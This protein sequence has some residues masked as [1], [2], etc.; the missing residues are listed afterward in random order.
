MNSRQAGFATRQ[1]IIRGVL[2]ALIAWTGTAVH[3]GGF[4]RAI[5]AT[6]PRVVKLYGLSAG[7]EKGYGSGVLVS[8]GGRVLTVFSLLIDSRDIRAVAFDGTTYGA[9]VVARDRDL[10]L[11]LLQLKPV[12]SSEGS[13]AAEF[14]ESFPFFE[15]SHETVL[16]P[17]D[18]VLS[19]GN[20]FKL[21]TGAEPVSI[22][23]GVFSTR[24]R[25]DARR[26]L[27][28]FPYR[29]DALV[30]DAITSNPGAPGSALVNLDGALVGMIGREVVSNLTHTHFNWAMPRDVLFEFVREAANPDPA[31]DFRLTEGREMIDMPHERFDPGIRLSRLGYRTILPFV[32]RVVVG[33]PA[34]FAGVRSDDLILNMNGRSVPDTATYYDRLRELRPGDSI[35]LVI[36]RGKTIVSIHLDTEGS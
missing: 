3:G 10:Q 32:E 15:L 36:Q 17:G 14:P 27:K 12:Q 24:T 11:A 2:L 22:A 25:L 6:T 31:G 13:S 34:D 20:A 16:R 18:W 28:D 8:A 33:S 7:L 1:V 23:H 35:D 5:E 29:G 26:R 19:A 9:D 30:I 21:A 4:D